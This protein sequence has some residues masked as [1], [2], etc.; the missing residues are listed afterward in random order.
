MP[1]RSERRTMP[2]RSSSARPSFRIGKRESSK[3]ATRVRFPSPA[4]KNRLAGRFTQVERVFELTRPY[5]ACTARAGYWPPSSAMPV[6]GGSTLL[7]GCSLSDASY[8]SRISFIARR[9]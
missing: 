5:R 6:A 1:S 9:V 8:A 3:L 4:L 7:I 2:E